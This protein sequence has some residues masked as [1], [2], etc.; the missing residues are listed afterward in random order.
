[1]SL[2]YWDWLPGVTNMTS[3]LGSPAEVSMATSGFRPGC[4]ARASRTS[5]TRSALALAW[6][7]LMPKP[8]GG[9]VWDGGATDSGT[10]ASCWASAGAGTAT[11]ATMTRHAPIRDRR[12][13]LGR[14]TRAIHCPYRPLDRSA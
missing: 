13:A 8:G 1:M 6:R 5:G 4:S 7:A 9:S 11:S 3:K 12:H 10:S 2:P 14:D